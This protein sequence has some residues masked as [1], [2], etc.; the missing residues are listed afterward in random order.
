[1]ITQN[2][3]NQYRKNKPWPA[4]NQLVVDPATGKTGYI[5]GRD[6]S[7]GAAGYMEVER[8]G[9]IILVEPRH[10]LVCGGAV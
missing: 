7:D 1:M 10:C 5:V 4:S 6:V 8:T 2:Q 3:I 9:E